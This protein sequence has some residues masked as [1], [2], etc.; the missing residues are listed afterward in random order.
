MRVANDPAKVE[1]VVVCNLSPAF[2]S[3]VHCYDVVEALPRCISQQVC[4]LQF[5]PAKPRRCPLRL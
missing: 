4:V 1:S 5:T 2:A 3:V